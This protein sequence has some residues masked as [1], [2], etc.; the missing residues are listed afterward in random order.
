MKTLMLLL[1]LMI[2]ALAED[3]TVN[4]KDYHNVKVGQVEADRVHITYDGGIGAVML[5]DL[6][7]DLKKRFNY[8]PQA[9]EKA[10][11]QKESAM[12][13]ADADQARKIAI[14]ALQDKIG[15]E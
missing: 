8:D 2:P 4:G 7:P 9:A 11:Q 10:S 13:Q 12:S 14:N 3:W 1:A 15:D 5:S 6:P